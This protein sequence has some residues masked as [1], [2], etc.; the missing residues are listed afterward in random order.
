M[1]DMKKYPRV[2][3]ELLKEHLS[4]NRQ[5]AFVSGPRQVG[6]TSVCRDLATGYVN[7]D[8]QDARDLVLKGPAEVAAFAGLLKLGAKP[9]VVAF[10]QIHRY[11][12][13]KTFL[14]GFFDV[15]GEESKVLVTG[16]SRLDVFK[17]GG[18]S[19]MGRYFYTG[20]TRSALLN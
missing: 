17:R 8:D 5:M 12:R 14:K 16:S 15:Y 11:A 18:D 19:L 20:C 13:W 4:E 9:R 1:V 2:Y 10:D 6:K 3:T 7:W